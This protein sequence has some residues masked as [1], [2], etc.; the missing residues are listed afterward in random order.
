MLSM[1]FQ[2]SIWTIFRSRIQNLNVFVCICFVFVFAKI[3]KKTSRKCLNSKNF[4]IIFTSHSPEFR[5]SH[6]WFKQTQTTKKKNY[7]HK[8][9]LKHDLFI[10]YQSK[11]CGWITTIRVPFKSAIKTKQVPGRNPTERSFSHFTY[12]TKSRCVLNFYA[13]FSLLYWKIITFLWHLNA[14]KNSDENIYWLAVEKEKKRR[15]KKIYVGKLFFFQLRYTRMEMKEKNKLLRSSC[16][17]IYAQI[18]VC[19]RLKLTD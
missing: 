2:Y 15:R 4:L 1:I 10:F 17:D 6:N 18:T 3:K 7:F 14:E 19:S 11:M 16:R 8:S 5:N 9:V 13:S 12:E